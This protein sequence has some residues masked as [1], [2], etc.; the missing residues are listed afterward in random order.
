M[1]EKTFILQRMLSDNG[2]TFGDLYDDGQWFCHTLE[3]QVREIPG[4]PVLEWKVYGQTAIP[5]GR[6]QISL[7]MSPKF[8][9][10]TIAVHGVEGF[11][12]IK[13]HSGE[14]VTDTLGCPLIG[15]Q[16]EMSKG[17]IRGGKLRGV[18]NRLK[19]RIEEYMTDGHEVYLDVLNHESYAWSEL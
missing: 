8:G 12:G 15:D 18:L 1:T 16:V 10:Q 13:I 2:N 9:P 5:A 14:D 11:E 6:Y 4:R 17:I 7:D 3:D 19:D